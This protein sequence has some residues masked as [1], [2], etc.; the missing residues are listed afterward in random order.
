MDDTEGM[1]VARE[2]MIFEK[3]ANVVSSL[4]LGKANNL[5]E[6]GDGID[7]G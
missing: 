2:P 6:I 4:G 3:F 1:R 5:N 7:T